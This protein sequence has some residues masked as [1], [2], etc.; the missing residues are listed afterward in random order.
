VRYLVLEALLHVLAD[1]VR[2]HDL[3]GHLGAL[4]RGPMYLAKA[5]RAQ[6]L[7]DLEL[8]VPDLPVVVA[9]ALPVD[10]HEQIDDESQECGKDQ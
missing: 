4:P 3:D 10:Q 1:A 9:L 5:A 8:V 2:G 6:M 7:A